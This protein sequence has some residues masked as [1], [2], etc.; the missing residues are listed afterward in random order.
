M[1]KKIVKSIALGIVIGCL[2]TYFAIYFLQYTGIINDPIRDDWGAVLSLLVGIVGWISVT[3][4]NDLAALRKLIESNT[5][6]DKETV[7]NLNRIDRRLIKIE[8]KLGI[9]DK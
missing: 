3:N 2:S 1:D 6:N 7:D 9:E 5:G 8:T 4:R